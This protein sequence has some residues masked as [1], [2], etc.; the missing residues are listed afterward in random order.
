MLIEQQVSAVAQSNGLYYGYFALVSDGTTILSQDLSFEV[1]GQGIGDPDPG[2]Y[3]A[4]N[5][6]DSI[7]VF[8]EAE[9]DGPAPA[10]CLAQHIVEIEEAPPEP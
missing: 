7:T 1:N 3:I 8:G 5:E 6:G 10:L 4:L 9:Y 2:Q